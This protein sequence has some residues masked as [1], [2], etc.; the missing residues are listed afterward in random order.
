MMTLEVAKQASDTFKTVCD[1][2]DKLLSM[3]VS[4]P[5]LRNIFY[6]PDDKRESNL[7]DY[8]YREKVMREILLMIEFSL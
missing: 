7:I 3:A 2:I 4:V 1:C 8:Q 5:S 6:R